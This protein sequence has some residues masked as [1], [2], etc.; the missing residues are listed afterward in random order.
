[1]EMVVYRMALIVLKVRVG[2]PLVC[3]STLRVLQLSAPIELHQPT[4]W[5]AKVEAR[6]FSLISA[7]SQSCNPCVTDGGP[8]GRKRPFA[9]S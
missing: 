1:M 8:A 5:R 6:Y 7:L 3:H 4:V 9:V 2:M